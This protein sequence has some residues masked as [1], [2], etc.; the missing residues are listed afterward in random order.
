MAAATGLSHD[1][2]LF[3]LFSLAHTM[4]TG[5]EFVGRG[6]PGTL[7]EEGFAWT[8]KYLREH[9]HFFS[10][11]GHREPDGHL[12]FVPGSLLITVEATSNPRKPNLAAQVEF[13][14]SRAY[15]DPV[16]DLRNHE[17]WLFVARPAAEEFLEHLLQVLRET[18]RDREDP[19]IVWSVDYDRKRHVYAIEKVRG[20]HGPGL[21]ATPDVPS[22]RI[23]VPRPK[24]FP[25]L[26]SHLSYPAVTYAIG[27]QLLMEL[28]FPEEERT[29]RE[30]YDTLEAN[31]VPFAYFNKAIGYLAQLVPELIEVSGRG[32]M[33]K[34][35]VKQNLPRVRT[36]KAK[37]ERI[38][39]TEDEQGLQMLVAAQADEQVLEPAEAP[40]E[41]SPEHRTLDEFME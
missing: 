34:L 1:D 20:E 32:R 27:R 5:Q 9:E 3:V 21:E 12:R 35:R 30:Y 36:I 31:A 33:Q 26:S 18:Q 6:T 2:L 38:L 14:S 15:R 8:T 23:E 40:L 13:Y 17:I 37:L 41:E 24:S 28:M 11:R 7:L 22:P 39:R 4:S 19:V 10:I 25:L 29:V 16:V